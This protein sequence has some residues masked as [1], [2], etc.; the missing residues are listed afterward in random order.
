MTGRARMDSDEFYM[1]IESR[2]GNMTIPEAVLRS[3]PTYYA[4]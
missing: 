1:A 3:D 4:S 2:P